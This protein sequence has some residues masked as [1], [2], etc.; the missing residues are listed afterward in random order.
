M[1]KHGLV[2][3]IDDPKML[4]RVK[5]N[6]FG[7]HDEI[8]TKD[9]PWS[10]VMSPTNS[11]AYQGIG[12]STNLMLNTLVCGT[13][14]DETRQDFFVLGTIPSSSAGVKDNNVRVREEADPNAGDSVGA[15]QPLS[16][17]G[18]KYPY[19]NVYETQSGHVKEYDDTPGKERIH[20]RHKSGTYESIEPNGTKI[21]KVV[22]DKYPLVMHDDVLE[23]H[24]SVNIITSE[25]C[26]VSVA[27]YLTAD[28]TGNCEV[29]V[30]GDSSTVTQGT[31]KVTSTG[32]VTIKQTGKEAATV[33][34]QSEYTKENDDTIYKGTIKL[35]GEV[36]ITENLVVEKL[37]TT[38]NS[39]DKIVL[40]SHTHPGDG[41]DSLNTVNTGPP[42]TV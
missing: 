16:T 21:E 15:M 29:T 2:V 25:N 17:Y 3:D 1:I 22:R 39:T 37:T 36:N 26:N 19:N 18:P 42:D 31:T 28:V 14:L 35:D 30:A 23:V 11:P 38:S 20:Q 6:V 8:D 5:V 34:V 7:I 9:L 4:G 24:G 40:D 13:F 12:H 33:I 32:D 41:A 10:L 27:G